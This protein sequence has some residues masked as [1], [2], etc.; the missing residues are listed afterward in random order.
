MATINEL[1]N[2]SKTMSMDQ[3]L[4]IAHEATGAIISQLKKLDISTDATSTF[5]INIFKLFVS[6]DK[7]TRND[8]YVLFKELFNLSIDKDTFF[9]ITNYGA[10]A[11]FI[12]EIDE[13]VD[14]APQEVAVAVATLGILIITA[15]GEVT[16]SERA[17]LERII[18]R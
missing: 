17:L 6:G 10:D 7:K 1:I 4:S 16:D 12:K 14:C 8:E 2:Q 18:K 9:N 3:R 13:L 5:L 15:D 11:N